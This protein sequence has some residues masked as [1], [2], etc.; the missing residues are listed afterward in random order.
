[1]GDVLLGVGGSSNAAVEEMRKREQVCAKEF[2]GHARSCCCRF[3]ASIEEL[4][5]RCR[6]GKGEATCSPVYNYFT[7]PLH[8]HMGVW[9]YVFDTTF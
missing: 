9:V 2:G 4:G 6:N 5:R 1:M 7:S 8:V 3:P